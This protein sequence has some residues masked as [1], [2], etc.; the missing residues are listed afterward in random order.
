MGKKT[1]R[2]AAIRIQ[3]ERIRAENPH[4]QQARI[5]NAILAN[6]MRQQQVAAQHQLELQRVDAA[7][8][9]QPEGLKKQAVMHARRD[10]K[11]KYANFKI[12]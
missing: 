8:H 5:E 1:K 2:P 11:N 9:R 12:D 7:L 10:L 6:K 3:N 4:R